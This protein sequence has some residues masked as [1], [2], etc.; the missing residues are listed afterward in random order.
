VFA[1]CG[2]SGTASGKKYA[3]TLD[4]FAAL[5]PKAEVSHVYRALA[6]EPNGGGARFGAQS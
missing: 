5:D 3:V 2:R 6:S 1:N 4:F